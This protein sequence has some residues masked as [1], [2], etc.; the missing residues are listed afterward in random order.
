MLKLDRDILRAYDIR[1]VVGANVDVTIAYAIGRAFATIASRRLGRRPRL[2]CAYDGRIS[3]P[4]LEKALVDGMVASGAEVLCLGVGPT[5]MLYFAVKTENRDGGVMVT[6]SH[7]PPE[8]NGFKL[9]LG[10]LPFWDN[11]IQLLGSVAESGAFVGG[12]GKSEQKVVEN[13]YVNRLL[14]EYN[15]SAEYSVVWDAGNGAAGGVIR[16]LTERLP[17]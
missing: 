15:P 2:C 1:G 4:Q 3:S 17:G 6:G 11:D 9:M 14:E 8:Y 7:N 16:A 5:P 10:H 13:C 12:L